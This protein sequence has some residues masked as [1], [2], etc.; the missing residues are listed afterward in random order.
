MKNLSMLVKD[1]FK[2]TLVTADKRL[3]LQQIFEH[4]WM[5]VEARKM[6]IRVDFSCFIRFHRF[7][8]IKKIAASYLAAQMAA[9]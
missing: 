2:K 3:T 9:K 8:K 5:K 6:T 4:P 1:L 7:S